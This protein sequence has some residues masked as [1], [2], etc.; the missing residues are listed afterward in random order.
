MGARGPFA[1][2]EAR[3]PPRVNSWLGA[4][5][6]QRKGPDME[7]E[8][9]FAILGTLHIARRALVLPIG[10]IG[11]PLFTGVGIAT[12]DLKSA[13]IL[14]IVGSLAIIVT[15]V[16]AFPSFLES[17]GLL[18]RRE[19]G[20]ILALVVGILSLIDFSIGT[21]P[22]VYTIRVVTDDD[23]E[24]SFKSGTGI[25]PAALQQVPTP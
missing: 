24:K 6:T 1:P 4:F 22:G 11:F 23:I 9:H 8:G 16:I 17:V 19:W 10:V 12:Q 2:V 7:K 20:R 3:P 15:G 13:G 25:S 21:A 18:Q 14:G 5:S